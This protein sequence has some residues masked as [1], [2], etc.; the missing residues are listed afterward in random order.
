MVQRSNDAATKDVPTLTK[1]EGC[2]LHM[3]QLGNAAAL[4]DDA[5]INPLGEEFVGDMVLRRR[6]N[7]AALREVLPMLKREETVKHTEKK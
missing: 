7:D 1:R 2:V 3:A 6:V 5:R 4:R